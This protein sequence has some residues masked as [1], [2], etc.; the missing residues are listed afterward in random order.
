[1]GNH[2]NTINGRRK[3]MLR[4]AHPTAPSAGIP[5]LDDVEAGITSAGRLTWKLFHEIPIQGALTSGAVGLYAATVFGVGELIAA[6][7]SA[8]FAY[9][10]FA[11][12]EPLLVAVE[13][14]IKFQMGELPK[15]DIDRRR[16]VRQAA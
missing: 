3:G 4:P 12:G 9:R 8:Y 7:L 14:T 1:M 5:L 15:S 6:G 11:F 13:K 10:M 2:S 16:R